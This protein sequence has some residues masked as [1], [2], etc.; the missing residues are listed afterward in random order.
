MGTLQNN[1]TAVGKMNDDYSLETPVK[2][3]LN[4][5]ISK[6]N[7][8]GMTLGALYHNFAVMHNDLMSILN[9]RKNQIPQYKCINLYN[10]SK[11][12][13]PQRLKEQQVFFLTEKELIDKL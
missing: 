3:F 12:V 9:S 11:K 8:F 1:C 10:E 2:A 4:E 6:A 5:N 7:V 13:N